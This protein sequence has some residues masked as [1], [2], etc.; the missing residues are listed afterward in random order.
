MLYHMWNSKAEMLQTKTS[1]SAAVFIIYNSCMFIFY[2]QIL[3]QT[4]SLTL[5]CI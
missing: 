2:P 1:Y 5:E 4:I 3:I